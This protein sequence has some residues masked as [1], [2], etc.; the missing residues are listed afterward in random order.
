MKITNQ[1][2]SDPL[3]F[4][5]QIAQRAMLLYPVS[6]RSTIRLLNYSEN[7]TYLIEDTET[8]DRAILRINRP[9]YH[10]KEELEAELI[11]MEAI[12]SHSSIVVPEPITGSN[13]ELVQLVSAGHDGQDPYHCVMFTFLA[14][15]APDEENES[16]L[17][18]QFAKLGEI[19]AHLHNHTSMWKD[20]GQLSRPTWDYETMLGSK[21]KWGRWQDGLDM[22]PERVEVLKQ[23]AGNV[24][25]RLSRFGKTPDRFGLVHADLRLANLLVEDEQIKVI[26]FDDCGFSW[27]LYDLAS[28]LSFMEHK[29]CVPNLIR[30]WLKGYETVRTIS[31]EEKEEIPTFIM[32]R[33]LTLVAWVGSHSDSE[34]AQE[35]GAEFTHK[36]VELAEQ[37]LLDRRLN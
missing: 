3:D 27:F 21:P 6:S 19:T 7:A 16:R 31:D 14:G 18:I 28:A 33:R 25:Q 15:S 37:Y 13:G 26:D 36:T 9:G 1:V 34:T 4:L 11:W 22:T 32:L 30:A 2:I 35:L 23:A 20:S 29:D 12:R 17:E 8:G 5:N 24:S 10:I